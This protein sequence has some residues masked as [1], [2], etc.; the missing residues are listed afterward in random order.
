MLTWIKDLVT[1]F[2]FDGIRI[3]TVSHVEKQFWTEFQEAAGTY[4]MGEVLRTNIT[5]TAE[6]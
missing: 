5:S 3:D 1:K 4:C 6:Y 2:G